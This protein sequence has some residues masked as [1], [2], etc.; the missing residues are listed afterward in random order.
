[1]IRKLT[2]GISTLLTTWSVGLYATPA[3]EKRIATIKIGGPAG[4]AM[5]L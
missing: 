2:S 1:M 5:S 3:G 4:T